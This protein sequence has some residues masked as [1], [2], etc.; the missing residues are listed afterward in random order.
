MKRIVTDVSKQITRDSFVGLHARG[1]HI[2]VFDISGE[3]PVIRSMAYAVETTGD[4]QKSV[5]WLL[6]LGYDKSRPHNYMVI[7]HT[8]IRETMTQNEH[9][10][11]DQMP[12][13]P[14]LGHGYFNMWWK[15]RQIAEVSRNFDVRVPT[16]KSTTEIKGFNNILYM[17]GLPIYRIIAAAVAVNVLTYKDRGYNRADCINAFFARFPSLEKHRSQVEKVIF[18]SWLDPIVESYIR[19]RTPFNVNK[20]TGL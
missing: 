11:V 17:I 4:G 13:E 1:S 10:Y 6:R 7:D 18:A 5:I 19:G 16:L 20:L 3:L 9:G 14:W 15:H 2:G 12:T 8:T